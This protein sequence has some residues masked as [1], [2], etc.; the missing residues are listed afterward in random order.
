MK[1]RTDFISNSSSVSYI[2]TMNEEIVDIYQRHF[3]NT[4]DPK[5]GRIFGMLYQDLAKNGTRVMLE[6]KEIFTRKIDFNTDDCMTDD[7]FKKS[8]EEVDFSKLTDE[9]LWPYI[10]GEYIMKGRISKL[11]GFG[12]TQVETY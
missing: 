4:R 7:T 1:I 6:G 3:K 9:E 2:L 12:S 11:N 5:E 8:I 10:F